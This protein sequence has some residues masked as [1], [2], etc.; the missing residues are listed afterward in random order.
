MKL[1]DNGMQNTGRHNTKSGERQPAAFS[2]QP[3]PANAQL[4]TS[5]S[6]FE[7]SAQMPNS[8]GLKV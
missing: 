3:V 4:V 6:I 8:L 1:V 7:D 2:L 5:N